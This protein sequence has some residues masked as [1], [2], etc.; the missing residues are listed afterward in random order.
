[1]A[2]PVG[3]PRAG[4]AGQESPLQVRPAFAGRNRW[5]QGGQLRWRAYWCTLS[6]A[7]GKLNRHK[8]YRVSNSDR[9]LAELDLNRRLFRYPCSYLVYT[10]AF[11]ALPEA[12]KTAVYRRMIEIL[13][14]A[15]ADRKY[16]SLSAVDRRNVLEILRETKAD[17]P[18]L[19]DTTR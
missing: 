2:R 11:D 16:A 3:G 19:T 14:G 10:E 7:T 18:R 8:K 17:F 6:A 13:S 12:V 9:S 15:D 4:G 5:P 1:V